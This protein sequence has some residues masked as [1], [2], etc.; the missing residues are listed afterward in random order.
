MKHE[1]SKSPLVL[2]EQAIMI[3]VFS[4]AATLCI[5]AFV[6]A[7]R[8][9]REMYRRDR[10]ADCCQTMAE[11]LKA[12]KGDYIVTAELLDGEF[13]DDRLIVSYDKDWQ[14]TEFATAEYILC[15]EEVTEGEYVTT[16]KVSVKEKNEG[17]E[18]FSLPVSWQEVAHE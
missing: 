5:Q 16:A 18:I 10:A 9:S 7:D 13:R 12:M 4:V 11:T 14:I 17:R 2:M 6:G 8:T 1:R 15:V 3:L